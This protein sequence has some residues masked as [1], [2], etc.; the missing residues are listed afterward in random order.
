MISEEILEIERVKERV[1][2]GGHHVQDIVV[3]RRYKRGLQNL[4]SKFIPISDYWLVIDNSYTKPVMV[5]E[6]GETVAEFVYNN[7]IWPQIKSF[8]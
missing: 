8:K 2:K 7:E 1:K 3:K 6:G 4:F 5:A